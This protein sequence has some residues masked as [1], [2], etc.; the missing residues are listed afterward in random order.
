MVKRKIN[1]LTE[2]LATEFSPEEFVHYEKFWMGK[3]PKKYDTADDGFWS[4]KNKNE[5]S[6]SFINFFDNG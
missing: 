5:S 1:W 2:N 6:N 4:S 3:E